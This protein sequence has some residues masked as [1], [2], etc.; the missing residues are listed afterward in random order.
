MIDFVQGL[1]ER[2]PATACRRRARAGCPASARMLTDEQIQA[3]VEYVR[4][5]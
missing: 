5:L 3:I 1:R 2:Q 4:S